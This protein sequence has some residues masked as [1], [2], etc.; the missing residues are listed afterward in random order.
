MIPVIPSILPDLAVASAILP[1]LPV[2]S[3]IPA[4]ASIIPLNIPTVV[5][6]IIP[7]NVASIVPAAIVPAV[8]APVAVVIPD[9]VTWTL[10]IFLE[11][12]EAAIPLIGPDLQQVRAIP[13]EVVIAVVAVV[14]HHNDPAVPLEAAP[15]VIPAIVAGPDPLD[16]AYRARPYAIPV[17]T[18]IADDD[19]AGDRTAADADVS[20]DPL[21]L[22]RLSEKER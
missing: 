17:A 19:S 16:S 3:T 8:V 5:S 20:I 4:V 18:S 2:V 14:V 10:T 9:V 21:G 11:P 22:C 13:I 12:V 15:P 7:A 6:A 1:A